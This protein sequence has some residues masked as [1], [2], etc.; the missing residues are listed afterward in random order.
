MS[1]LRYAMLGGYLFFDVN[2]AA[3]R[4]LFTQT[5]LPLLFAEDSHFPYWDDMEAFMQLSEFQTDEITTDYG[6]ELYMLADVLR[7]IWQNPRRRGIMLFR[8]IPHE[9]TNGNPRTLV[10]LVE[11]CNNRPVKK[12]ETLLKYAETDVRNSLF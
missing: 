12:L 3:I 4:E 5:G 9:S 11:T 1:I 7:P 8:S 2:D 6:K 10:S